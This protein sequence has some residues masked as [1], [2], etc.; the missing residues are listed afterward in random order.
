MNKF[1][2]LYR[3]N[4]RVGYVS[5]RNERAALEVWRKT[6]FEKAMIMPLTDVFPL[7]YYPEYRTDPGTPL[8]LGLFVKRNSNHF[9][10]VER[11]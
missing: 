2:I 9:W 8:R 1:N 4:I 3:G 5:A 10:T 6:I 11:A 7:E